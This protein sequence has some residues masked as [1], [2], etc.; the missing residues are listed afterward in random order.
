MAMTW[1]D[2][3]LV[4]PILRDRAIR[5]QTCFCKCGCRAEGVSPVDRFGRIEPGI[6]AT[7]ATSRRWRMHER[8]TS[9]AYIFS[10]DDEP[11]RERKVRTIYPG[12]RKTATAYVRDG[13]ADGTQLMLTLNKRLDSG[14]ELTD[15]QVEAVLASM[16]AT[17]RRV[18]KARRRVVNEAGKDA[19]RVT[20]PPTIEP[21]FYA[22]HGA[23]VDW[24]VLQIAKPRRGPMAGCIVVSATMDGN[25]VEIGVQGPSRKR[26]GLSR[27][28]AFRQPVYR[29][30]MTHLVRA[31]AKQPGAARLAYTQLMK[32]TE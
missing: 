7:C 25:M 12:E 24:V 3:Q 20:I 18:R 23:E 14:K 19:L 16:N 6:C 28:L 10:E 1:E 27:L 26:E 17:E 21:G 11:V 30:T 2:T 13:A 4:F 5:E 9:A 29:G 15:A 32:E 31:L 8:A 22:V